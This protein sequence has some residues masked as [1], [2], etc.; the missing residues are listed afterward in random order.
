[1]TI[2][3]GILAPRSIVIA[4]DCEESTSE[5]GTLKSATSK[6]T[7]D[8]AGTRENGIIASKSIGI[9]GAGD[10]AYL[11][12]VKRQVVDDFKDPETKNV[13][14]FEKKLKPRIKRFCGDHVKPFKKIVDNLDV[15]LIVG[16]RIRSEQCLWVTSLNT[17]RRTSILEVTAIGCGE[18]SLTTV[19]GPN[20]MTVN[21]ELSVSLAA[22]Y[23]VLFAKDFVVGCGKST[24][25]VSIR[26]DALFWASPEA[27]EKLNSIFRRYRDFEKHLLSSLL[28][29][30]DLPIEIVPV[31]TRKSGSH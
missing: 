11:A 6:I 21:D 1:M 29:I 3:V 18:K 23:G 7:Y 10:S 28:G 31:M 25:M 26:R 22:A 2:G 12:V 19:L 13:D 20:L 30:P 27:I 17:A 16:A 5:P 9:S 24:Q 15:V 8:Y 4:A 14:D